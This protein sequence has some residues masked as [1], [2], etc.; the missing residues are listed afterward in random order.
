M[1]NEEFLPNLN[2]EADKLKKSADQVISPAAVS[3]KSPDP[4]RKSPVGS[5][6]LEQEVLQIFGERLVTDRV[7]APA[8][9]GRLSD[10][11]SDILI[12]GLPLEERKRLL[13]DFPPPA[14]CLMMDP[15]KL[16]FEFKAAVDSTI[17]KRDERIIE[18]QEKISASLAGISKTI[19]LVL[20][21][22]PPEKKQLLEPL[23]GVMRLLADLQHDETLIRRSLILKNIAAPVRDMLKDRPFDNWLFAKDLSEQLKAAKAVQ[24]SSKDLKPTVTVSGNKGGPKNFKGPTPREQFKRNFY[25]RGNGRKYNYGRYPF[26]KPSLRGKPTNQR[27]EQATARKN[28]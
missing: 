5:S 23:N 2:N 9:S 1:S 22:N 16:N 25:S 21:S 4:G 7:L 15:P 6:D 10:I 12:K 27:L 17:Q 20:K 13:K 14:N 19:E 11:W 28:N 8:V 3:E 24:Q 26:Q 18:K